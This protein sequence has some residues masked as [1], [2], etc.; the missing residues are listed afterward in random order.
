MKKIDLN[1]FLIEFLNIWEDA[2]DSNKANILE[3]F[4]SNKLWTEYMLGESGFLEKISN[5][6][7]V[8][9]RPVKFAKEYYTVD[10]LFVGGKNI[11][12]KKD[13]LNY[14]SNVYALIEHENAEDVETEMWKLIH[15]RSPLKVL[16]F[17]DYREDEKN[18][19]NWA[20]EK[21]EVLLKMLDEVNEF[22]AESIGTEYLFLVGRK[23]DEV[24]LPTWRW[25]SNF[26]RELSEL[27][28]EEL[29]GLSNQR[30]KDVNDIG[31]QIMFE[32]RVDS[33][34]NESIPEE[35]SQEQIINKE[36]YELN[37]KL[38]KQNKSLVF[39]EVK[40]SPLETCY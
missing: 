26:Q 17:Y 15:M 39:H 2:I 9:E 22:N 38:R 37:K 21:V 3:K 36:L 18:K 35:M 40:V 24:S 12:G 1:S 23:K 33:S 25:A 4:S 7:N 28:R 20:P 16:I 14:P 11:Y 32:L 13:S 8:N 34:N 30:K 10:A 29:I 5:K 31:H 27:D 6:F 19:I